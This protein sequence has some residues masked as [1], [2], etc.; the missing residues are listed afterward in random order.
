MLTCTH[1]NIKRVIFAYINCLLN[2][3]LKWH[4]KVFQKYVN[5]TWIQEYISKNCSSCVFFIVDT[6][7]SF[8]KSSLLLSPI[9]LFDA[10][11][12][13]WKHWRKVKEEEGQIERKRKRGMKAR[14][15]REV[16]SRDSLP[17]W[18]WELQRNCIEIWKIALQGASRE[19]L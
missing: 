17:G 8:K 19:T 7:I 11:W 5:P 9:R 15:I 2:V 16:W 6:I 10:V 1:L 13:S 14:G 18:E 12:I 4:W 3:N